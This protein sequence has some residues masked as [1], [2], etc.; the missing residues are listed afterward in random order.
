M[1]RSAAPI[2]GGGDDAAAARRERAISRPLLPRSG[3]QE[4]L[5]GSGHAVT[6]SPRCALLQSC[7]RA[8]ARLV[9]AWREQREGLFDPSSTCIPRAGPFRSVQRRSLL[10]HHR[11]RSSIEITLS[12]IHRVPFQLCVLV[13]RCCDLTWFVRL[14]QTTLFE[15]GLL[16]RFELYCTRLGGI[17][18]RG[19]KARCSIVPCTLSYSVSP[20]PCS[21][22]VQLKEVTGR[23]SEC[24]LAP[25][26]RRSIVIRTAICVW[27]TDVQMN[28][29]ND[30]WK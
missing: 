6:L 9:H 27:P 18:R 19:A 7:T 13:V 2:T 16:D 3:Q 14:G 15:W 8:A 21:S 11:A 23:G 20:F 22:V 1:R 25:W 26:R 30:P 5:A 4:P 24:R 28:Q 12:S 29:I 10:H 17:H